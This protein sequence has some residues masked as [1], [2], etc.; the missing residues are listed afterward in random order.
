MLDVKSRITPVS[1]DSLSAVL[2]FGKRKRDIRDAEFII[3]VE[4]SIN[5]VLEGGEGLTIIIQYTK[6]FTELLDQYKK[7]YEG[8]INV[9]YG[10]KPNH[11]F[12]ESMTADAL[13]IKLNIAK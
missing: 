13:E 1:K 6:E 11:K 5:T 10:N 12:N 4:K 8:V 7:E 2:D 3:S 9:E